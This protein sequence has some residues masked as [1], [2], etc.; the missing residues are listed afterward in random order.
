[1]NRKQYVY[2]TKH[3]VV[4]CSNISYFITLRRLFTSY[5]SQF[6]QHSYSKLYFIHFWECEV[7]FSEYQVYICGRA[8]CISILSPKI[9]LISTFHSVN[10]QI[11]CSIVSN[12]LTVQ[13]LLKFYFYFHFIFSQKKS[14]LLF[15]S[16][17]FIFRQGSDLSNMLNNRN[18]IN[19]LNLAWSCAGSHQLSCF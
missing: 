17:I 14:M 12:T 7:L 8:V 16:N 6:V 18:L 15:K 5:T 4:E 10:L 19:G 2:F 11:R 1:M 3:Y 9:F 13:K